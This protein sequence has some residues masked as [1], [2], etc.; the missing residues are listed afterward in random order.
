M[1]GIV[2]SKWLKDERGEKKGRC[3][4]F[5]FS[6]G[7]TRKVLSPRKYETLT[8]EKPSGRTESWGFLSGINPL[9]QANRASNP[10]VEL[11]RME[12]FFER[13]SRSLKRMKAL[14]G[15]SP[16]VLEAE[17]CLQG[18]WMKLCRAGNQT[19]VCNFFLAWYVGKTLLKKV[20]KRHPLTV[21]AEGPWV[22]LRKVCKFMA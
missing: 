16:W 20:K 7:N 1:I 12:C 14:K 11:A 8:P 3:F 22:C 4:F 21:Y 19:R 17:T 15:E 13:W 5:R 9:E 18:F 2:R 10:W 6:C